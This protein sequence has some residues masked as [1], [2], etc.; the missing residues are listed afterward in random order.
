MMHL[1]II[2]E[3]PLL[4]HCWCSDYAMMVRWWCADDALMM[5][6]WCTDIALMMRW[7]C[8]NDALIVRWWCADDA[9]MMH[10]WCTE[11]DMMHRGQVSDL[12]WRF[13]GGRIN[14]NKMWRWPTNRVN[15]EQS[16]SGRW[17]G[18]LLQKSMEEWHWTAFTIL[19]MFYL[20]SPIFHD[21]STSV[22]L[23]CFIQGHQE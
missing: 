9:L 4:M 23:R 5:H 10:W 2:N 11:Y 8:A 7:W 14:G 20:T 1:W 13:Y 15:I 18:R 17:T 16:A 3:D 21:K 12:H 6:W 22:A 19:A